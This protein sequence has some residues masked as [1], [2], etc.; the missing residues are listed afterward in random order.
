MKRLRS[1]AGFTIVELTITILVLGVVTITITNLFLGVRNTQNQASY[2]QS[3]THAAQREVET[4]RNDSYNSLTP[5][6]N[7][8]F[9]S[10]LPSNLRSGTGTVVVSSPIAD[11]RRVDVTVTY[12]ANGQTRQVTISSTIGVIGISQ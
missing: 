7:I 3:A 1:E 11:L 5:G 4:L 12:K 6:Q 10:Q 9:T 2:L 8:D